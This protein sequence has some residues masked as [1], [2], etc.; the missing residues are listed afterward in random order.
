ML[1]EMQAAANEG[2][3]N[4][5]QTMAATRKQQASL[6]V[7]TRQGRLVVRSIPKWH[8]LLQLMNLFTRKRRMAQLGNRLIKAL[9]DPQCDDQ[10][11]KQIFEELESGYWSFGKKRLFQAVC[12]EKPSFFRSASVTSLDTPKINLR[13]VDKISDGKPQK[14]IRTGCY[15]TETPS[16]KLNVQQYYRDQLPPGQMVC[17]ERLSDFER[18]DL[19]RTLT[20]TPGKPLESTPGR[21]FINKPL[22]LLIDFT[23]MPPADAASL[24]ELFDT[25]PRFQGR[26]ISPEVKIVAMVHDKMLDSDPDHPGHDFWRRMGSMGITELPPEPAGLKTD[27]GL[28]NQ[29]L[30]QT[31]SAHA[32]SMDLYKTGT[33]WQSALFGGIELDEQG[34]II[35]REGALAQLGEPPE[36]HL[37]NAPWE[38]KDFI[39]QLAT[40]LRNG[41]FMANGQWIK[42]PANL[43]L[44]RS[45]TRIEDFNQ[46]LQALPVGNPGSPCV[47]VNE[48]NFPLLMS[49][50]QLKNGHFSAADVLAQTCVGSPPRAI[51]VTGKLSMHQWIQL[52][53]KLETME[54]VPGLMVTEATAPP[55]G[56]ETGRFCCKEFAPGKAVV[57]SSSPGETGSQVFDYEITA[58]TKIHTLFSRIP[59]LSRQGMTFELTPSPLLKALQNGRPV[60]LHGLDTNPDIARQLESLLGPEPYVLVQG[61][62]IP[63]PGLHLTCVVARPEKLGPLW[64]GQAGANYG[65]RTP[66]PELHRVPEGYQRQL[67]NL[68]RSLKT[69]PASSERRYPNSAPEMTAQWLTKL[70]RQLVMEAHHDGVATIQNYHWRKALNDVIAKEYRGDPQV[71][72]FIKARI[73]AAF[74]DLNTVKRVDRSKVAR[75]LEMHPNLSQQDVVQHYWTLARYFTPACLPEISN[76]SRPALSQL[77]AILPVIVSCAPPE[78]QDR[79]AARLGCKPSRDPAPDL[80]PGDTYRRAYN[81]LV[82]TGPAGWVQKDKPLH[83]QAIQLTRAIQG[84]DRSPE[85]ISQLLPAYIESPLPDE[86]FFS[87]SA[88]LV[89]GAGNHY[90]QLRRVQRLKQKVLAHPVVMLKGEAGTGKTFT[91]QAV[92]SQLSTVEPVVLSMSPEH[93]QEDLFGADQQTP[94]RVRI[95]RD[96]LGLAEHSHQVWR[97]LCHCAEVDAGS[98][99]VNITFNKTLC[100]RL[101]KQL[102][103][104]ALY[105]EVLNR[106]QDFHSEFR[107]GPVLEWA[108]HRAEDGD[109]PVLILDEANLAKAGVLQPLLDG[110]NRRPKQISI[111]GKVIPLSDK[112]RVILTGNPDYYDGRMV[113]PAMREQVVTLSYMPFTEAALL[114]TIV[115]PG[116]PGH[117]SEPVKQ[118]AIHAT[119]RLYKQYQQVLT[120]HT[121]GPR[122]IKDILCRIR[123]YSGEG[124]T[125]TKQQLNGIIW[126]SLGETLGSEVKQQDKAGRAM[127]HWYLAHY[128][129]DFALVNQLQNQFIAFYDNLKKTNRGDGFDYD[130]PSVKRLAFTVWRE[131]HKVG[132]KCATLIEGE[133]GRGKDALLDRVLPKFDRI[134]ASV[135][136]WEQLKDMA[137][138]A[139]QEGRVLVISELNILPS[140]YSEGL[141]NGVL[142][143]KAHKNFKLYVTM[144]PSEYSGREKFSEAMQSRCTICRIPPFEQRELLNIVKRKYSGNPELCEWL[145]AN[146]CRL[147]DGLAE[148]HTAVN[149]PLAKLLETARVLN[150]LPEPLWQQVFNRRYQLAIRA[151]NRSGTG[152]MP[153]VSKPGQQARFERESQVCHALNQQQ[154][155]PL[156]VIL[157]DPGQETGYDPASHTLTL[158]DNT[159]LGKLYRQASVLMASPE[160]QADAELLQ[161]KVQLLLDV[162]PSQQTTKTS[163]EQ[164]LV[165]SG[166]EAAETDN[167]KGKNDKGLFSAE[168]LAGLLTR[169]PLGSA[170]SILGKAPVKLVTRALMLIPPD[171][172]F[173]LLQHLPLEKLVPLISTLPLDK[174]TEK[175]VDMDS[176]QLDST[177]EHIGPMMNTLTGTDLNQAMKQIQLVLHKLS[178]TAQQKLLSSLEPALAE[179]GKKMETMPEA[180]LRR[181]YENLAP[182]IEARPQCLPQ[183]VWVRL[184]NA[185]RASPEHLR[186]SEN[187]TPDP[188]NDSGRYSKNGKWKPVVHRASKAPQ[189]KRDAST[190]QTRLTRIGKRYRSTIKEHTPYT[191]LVEQLINFEFDGW[192]NPV[193]GQPERLLDRLRKAH[194]P[195]QEHQEGL[196]WVR[197]MDLFATVKQPES[198]KNAGSK[199]SRLWRPGPEQEESPE[200]LQSTYTPQ[201]MTLN[202]YRMLNLFA[203]MRDHQ[204]LSEEAYL[205]VLGRVVLDHQLLPVSMVVDKIPALQGHPVYGVRA[206]QLL[207]EY[208]QGPMTQQQS[209]SP[210]TGTTGIKAVFENPPGIAFLDKLLRQ[211][212]ISREWRNNST[213][214]DPE[215]Q[216]LARNLPAFPVSSSGKDMPSVVFPLDPNF[217]LSEMSKVVK[218]TPEFQ[219][220]WEEG[221]IRALSAMFM[222]SLR[223]YADKARWQMIIPHD[224]SF[225]SAAR[226]LHWPAGCYGFDDGHRFMAYAVSI[227]G[228]VPKGMPGMRSTDDFRPVLDKGRVLQA[229]GQPNARYLGSE[230]VRR[231][232]S[233][234]IR[235]VTPEMLQA[236]YKAWL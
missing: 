124:Q 208:Y 117:W 85:T 40:A 236:G 6:R 205:Q 92:A 149:L 163:I 42:L 161:Q 14:I 230:E 56:L 172:V 180:E 167:H 183:S 33:D 105:F 77:S 67:Q 223:K 178:G 220:G 204:L 103:N 233:D 2:L 90:R 69:I 74:P 11:R 128:P 141:F 63:L 70:E 75:W 99:S 59:M 176:D 26:P 5:L 61:N 137:K 148:V 131:Q 73:N 175:I 104:D 153:E 102:N 31:L 107:P 1:T 200:D 37:I 179:L 118:H 184:S 51:L 89:S 160:Q 224:H 44:A 139:M 78:D 17:I 151:L 134:N 21:L 143:G 16:E 66:T 123:Q 174:I 191:Q 72:G 187:N 154:E 188:G 120:G 15:F 217:I 232:I 115:A 193:S 27:A 169:L 29:S 210:R 88:A 171:K 229:L 203:L 214:E 127:K 79:L 168:R 158:T 13:A 82:A 43:Q 121:F 64:Q 24:N 190:G 146:H 181:I 111:H 206:E 54:P 58:E 156:R 201:K 112:H 234:F 182:M 12:N 125:P 199:L 71:Y 93:T 95:S 209:S 19:T 186:P 94:T 25:P 23:T 110:L 53:G 144:N 41:G 207:N 49:S 227:S 140:R 155:E 157:T 8:L 231:C 114:E 36:L 65:T 91:A 116:L 98:Q 147:A 219:K 34:Q 138:R 18:D 81:M 202:S 194:T 225:L 48:S 46:R 165:E 122:D 96:T 9:A 100:D 235:G 145:V 136:N 221:N 212:A 3:R 30:Q 170:I 62:R 159:D 101:H 55:V 198:D 57:V 162:K 218:Q 47:P 35:F 196:E 152:Q 97:A 38:N 32:K 106:F 130:A 135:E 222:D 7:V 109:P 195:G 60:R 83:E 213:G 87:L 108:L 215:A 39:R 86:D 28:L 166:P 150:D 226:E 132:G 164:T 129:C 10:T 192:M 211:R 76:Y 228:V 133:A 52:L 4:H 84:S 185:E 20:C 45:E 177:V 119:M 216:R 173:V 113:D 68:L 142:G 126:Q 80:F 189:L 197:V 22:V 50:L